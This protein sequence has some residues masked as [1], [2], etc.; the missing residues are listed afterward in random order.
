MCCEG[1][2]ET[3]FYEQHSPVLCSVSR[4]PAARCCDQH[5]YIYT[6]LQVAHAIDLISMVEITPQSA[7]VIMVMR[8]I[9]AQSVQSS[10]ERERRRGGGGMGIGGGGAAP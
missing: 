2:K 8:H 3:F 6:V 7:V 1:S 10:A 9:A 5:M 4:D